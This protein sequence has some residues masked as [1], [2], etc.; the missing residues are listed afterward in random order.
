MP[1]KRSTSKNLCLFCYVVRGDSL[2]H[3]YLFVLQYLSLYSQR[4]GYLPAKFEK[5]V[6][7][8][9]LQSVERMEKRKKKERETLFIVFL[10]TLVQFYT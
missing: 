8:C 5:L 10:L 3:C 7:D 2:A 9:I 6:S 4:L 1:S